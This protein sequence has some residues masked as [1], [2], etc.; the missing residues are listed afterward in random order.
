MKT[1]KQSNQDRAERKKDHKPLKP[2]YDD[3]TGKHS[4]LLLVEQKIKREID[5]VLRFHKMDKYTSDKLVRVVFN[6][7]KDYSGDIENVKIGH[8]VNAFCDLPNFKFHFTDLYMPL[9][10]E[11]IRFRLNRHHEKMAERHNQNY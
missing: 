9:T 11:T 1:V 2:K 4:A 6:A 3:R 10:L 8:I 5:D 7:L